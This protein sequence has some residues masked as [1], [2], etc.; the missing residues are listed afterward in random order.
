M[1][2]PAK[3]TGRQDEGDGVP[4]SM[5]WAEVH[6]LDVAV[7]QIDHGGE[8]EGVGCCREI[9]PFQSEL[10]EFLVGRLGFDGRPH[11]CVGVRGQIGE[12]REA[13]G[14]VVVGVGD[15]G[16][17]D[18]DPGDARGGVPDL[19]TLRGSRAG[20]DDD[21]AVASGDQAD[22]DRRGLR[23]RAPHPVADELKRTQRELHERQP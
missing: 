21:A 8:F 11:A 4:G 17:N 3:T 13:E 19:A 6:D 14:V 5:A 7:A 18:R 1:R 2:S 10:G 22:V 9:G 20:V 23:H 12:G 16:G 15:D